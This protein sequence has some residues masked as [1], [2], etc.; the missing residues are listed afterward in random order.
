MLKSLVIILSVILLVTCG[1]T[2]I[3]N[4]STINDDESIDAG[5]DAGINEK[6]REIDVEEYLRPE[7]EEK[8]EVNTTKLVEPLPIDPQ[9]TTNWREDKTIKRIANEIYRWKNR[10]GSWY[11]CGKSYNK[12]EMI[13]N[14]YDWA[15]N[16]VRAANT[17]STDKWKMDPD[18][19]KYTAAI[20]SGFDRCALGIGSRHWGI[21]HKILPYKK[22]TISYTKEEVL[23]VVKDKRHKK[24]FRASDLGGFQLMHPTF[25]SGPVE[26]MVNLTKGMNVVAN[27]MLAR[28]HYCKTVRPWECWWGYSKE[29]KISR[30]FKIKRLKKVFKLPSRYIMI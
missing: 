3:K 27:E 9:P 29:R 21:K 15:Y 4:Q 24:R 26:D 17:I 1:G 19:F 6:V 23:K 30:R 14:A 11:E 22:M 13:E 5:V 8:K 18:G 7:K 2:S 16:M 25:Y 10:A 12:E 20:E 28:K